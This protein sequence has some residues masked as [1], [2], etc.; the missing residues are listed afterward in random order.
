M[1]AERKIQI[2]VA[3]DQEMVRSGVKAL[4]VGTEIVVVAEAQ[5]SQTAVKLALEMDVDLALLDIRMPDGD[6]LSA[7]NHIKLEKP[8]LPVLLFSAFDNL[9]SIAQAIDLGA[10]GSLLKGCSRDEFLNAI[11]VV[12]AGENIWNRKRRQSASR[13]LRTPRLAGAMETSLTEREGEVLRQVALGLSNKQIAVEMKISPIT[14]VE[15]VKNIL[16]KIGV[17]NRTQAAI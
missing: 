16:H 3:D 1:P 12:A 13:S 2:L 9:A 10:S 11:R 7:L 6:G 17:T 5:C 8:K 14:V 15:Y 4:L